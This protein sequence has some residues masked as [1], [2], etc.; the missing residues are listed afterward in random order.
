[1]QINSTDLC[2]AS[3]ARHQACKL[4]TRQSQLYKYFIIW[5][6]QGLYGVCVRCKRGDLRTA[7]TCSPSMKLWSDAVGDRPL[8]HPHSLSNT[9]GGSRTQI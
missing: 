5:I 3:A 7:M 4:P 9:A 6:R 1:M 8:W 2:S